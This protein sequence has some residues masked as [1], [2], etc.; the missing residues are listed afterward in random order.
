MSS[1]PLSEA[2][3]V[4]KPLERDIRVLVVDDADELRR[5]YI[6]GLEL[7]GYTAGQ[8][9]NGTEAL[10]RIRNESYDAVLLDL[11]MPGM[12]GLSCL[13][14]LKEERKDLEVLII[15][16]YGT[17]SS[18][19][20]AM[21]LGACDYVAK[22]F[23][24][25]ELDQRL[26]RAV[27]ARDLR[28]ENLHLRELLREKYHYE[29]LIGKSEAM[30]RVFR[31]I[32]QAAQSRA[33]VLL[34][35]KSGT[36]KELAARAIH[37][38]SPF[39]AGPMVTV[40]CGAIAPTV[41]ESELFGHVKG[42]F[43]GAVQAKEGLF[44]QARGG[45]L[46]FDEIGELPLE[47]QTKL[48][49]SIQEREIR[50]VG[51]DRTYPVDVRIVAATHRDL[52]AATKEGRFREDLFYRL[53]VICIAIPALDERKD[54]IPLLLAHFLKKH[55]RNGRS[56][57]R[58]SGQAMHA[59]TTYNWPGNV[60][61]LE[62][63]VERA[64]A[65]GQGAVLQLSDLP[66]NLAALVDSSPVAASADTTP[67]GKLDELRAN[68]VELAGVQ[69]E[70]QA[71]ASS[72]PLAPPHVPLATTGAAAALTGQAKLDDIERQAI[73]ATLQ[74]TG[75][76]RSACARILGIDK[77]TLYRKLKKYNMAESENETGEN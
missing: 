9:R 43:T 26:Q 56:V 73:L 42:A 15:T 6:Q 37:F 65:M 59:L 38:G 62:N 28:W 29:N 69:S 63:V 8:A 46:F 53:N 22:P 12:D 18:A 17:I 66:P 61:E 77:S 2:V 32:R 52:L 20:E 71:V 51:S 64:L 25:D 31:M 45:T 60:R 30:R 19:V 3:A 58:I 35:G 76:D 54:D 57:E 67:I 13:R 68:D 27:Q 7:M 55:S 44:R 1:N 23:S 36:G 21:R 11:N 50:P 47:M 72:G 49:R 39:A 16:G 40:D 4:H 10:D 33:T 34:Q 24:F 14:A 5:A 41:I 70:E 75:G 48:L 74:C